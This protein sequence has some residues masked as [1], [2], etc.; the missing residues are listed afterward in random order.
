MPGQDGV[1]PFTNVRPN[2]S[3][4]NIESGT[5]DRATLQQ[6]DANNHSWVYLENIK[7]LN[8]LVLIGKIADH[9]EEL[10]MLAG[11]VVAFINT[12]T[13]LIFGWIATSMAFA[14]LGCICGLG[15][16][17]LRVNKT[18][19]HHLK[20]LETDIGGLKTTIATQKKDHKEALE[21][22]AKASAAQLLAQQTS[23][24]ELIEKQKESYDE[25]IKSQTEV[26]TQ[27]K[28]DHESVIGTLK[29][30]HHT[31]LEAQKAQLEAQKEDHK[32]WLAADADNA[33]FL[34]GIIATY[35]RYSA[36]IDAKKVLLEELEKKRIAGEEAFENR[37][38]ELKGEISTLTEQLTNLRSEISTLVNS[39]SAELE[40][41]RNLVGTQTTFLNEAGNRL[42]KK[43]NK[44]NSMLSFPSPASAPSSPMHGGVGSQVKDPRRHTMTGA[45]IQRLR[46]L[47][48]ENADAPSADMPPNS[49]LS[50]STPEYVHA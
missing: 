19:Q 45:D 42:S 2:P 15:A 22:Q 12:A 27:Q 47:N 11:M 6:S 39:A 21:N 35:A 32:L 26:N 29:S 8:P 13:N 16:N 49:P 44:S 43:L 30:E 48:E 24:D 40:Q 25:I 9:W 38:K 36:E 5:A 18:M 14:T 31:L 37:I 28:L 17:A 1:L 7:N 33:K 3:P 34:E 4:S 10:I 23:Y 20:T 41:H 46:E 50:R